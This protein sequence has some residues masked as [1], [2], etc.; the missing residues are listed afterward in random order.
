MKAGVFESDLADIAVEDL[1]RWGC[2]DLTK[3]ILST[4][5]R[6]SHESEII[7]RAIL[8]YAIACPRPEATRFVAE[9]KRRKPELMAEVEEAL[10]EEK[11]MK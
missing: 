1:R 7:H 9:Q 5:E 6:K 4:F 11:I 3:E 2:W 10:R 8:R